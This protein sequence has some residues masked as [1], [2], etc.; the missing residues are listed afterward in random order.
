LIS[1]FDDGTTKS[2]FGSGWQVSTDS[3]RGG[4]SKGEMHVV[5]GGAENS[6]S[7]LQIEGE[8]APGANS[9]SG[10]MFFPGSQPMIPVNLSSKK[11]ITF[12]TRGDG[13]TY[14]LMVFAQANGYIP[15]M[16]TFIAGPEW[17]KVSLPLAEFNTD[18]HDLV[19]ILF[20]ARAEPGHFTFLIDNVR[21]E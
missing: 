10:A 13:R 21:L 7:A 9:W 11:A 19:G 15:A 1:D 18:G 5:D 20:G 6:K 4:T 17:K 12:W 2:S 8:I 3:I 16:K 14:S